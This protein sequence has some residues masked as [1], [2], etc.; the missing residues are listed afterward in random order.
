MIT[1]KSE[2]DP[3]AKEHPSGN[4]SSL[5]D[6]LIEE[7]ERERVSDVLADP[8]IPPTNGSVPPVSD[9]SPTQEAPLAPKLPKK[10][11]NI[12]D[13]LKFLGA[14]FVVGLIFFGSFLAYIVFNPENAQFFVGFG[15]NPADIKSLLAT[16]V[17]AIFGTVAFL[18]SIVWLV[19]LF[20]A[21]RTKKEYRR[22][23][24]VSVIL[25]IFT[26]IVL[27]SSLSLWAYLIQIIDASDYENPDGGVVVYDNDRLLSEQY[28]D[29][30]KMYDF[31]N[32]IGPIT[33][34]FDLAS[35]VR[36]VSRKMQI[37]SYSIDFD[38]D[39]IVD[40]TG[41]DPARDQSIVYTYESVGRFDPVLRY[42]GT[43]TVTREPTE[44]IVSLPSIDIVALVRM[45][46]V[47]ERM[48]GVRARFDAEDLRPIGNVE[49]YVDG[50]SGSAP[51]S[52]DYRFAPSKIF[53]EDG[54]VCLSV[55]QSADEPASC[56]RI[57]VVS[58]G[59]RENA[60]EGEIFE[61]QDVLD[62]L[63]Y[64][65]DL[66][67]DEGKLRVKNGGIEKYEW[68]VDNSA[69]ISADPTAEHKFVGYGK[70]TIAVN[71]T[72]LIGN[73]RKIEKEFIIRER[74]V[75][76]LNADKQSMPV[77]Y[78]AKQAS[79]ENVEISYDPRARSYAIKNVSVPSEFTFD[80]RDMRVTDPLYT[81]EKA[82]WDFDNDGEYETITPE[83]T[84]SVD[85]PKRH[86]LTSRYV[87]T[88]KQKNDT[89]TIIET[90]TIDAERKEVYPDFTIKTS[91]DYVPTIVT[92]DASASSVQRGT[93]SKF[94]I[95][96][97]QGREPQEGDA[98]QNS[99]FELPGTYDIS[100][101]VIRDDG[102]KATLTKK[103]V[104]KEQDNRIVIN[105]SVSS[106]IV[107][108]QVDFDSVGTIGQVETY[109]WKF[110]DGIVSSQPTPT[111]TYEQAGDYTVELRVKFADGSVRTQSL[112]F[113]VKK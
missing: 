75:L 113:S 48:G 81:L 17:S 71:L 3:L 34:R 9:V 73:T 8:A 49:W 37:T 6:A 104:L 96:F 89:Q 50:D 16:L 79:N 90:V 1:P 58:V 51:A 78:K 102:E 56:D 29:S 59:G 22:K 30:A 105:T 36:V 76:D 94:I 12:V 28:A 100:V 4:E 46:V 43:D 33:L 60:I 26:G 11:A 41:T 67:E 109:F 111:H 83:A 54:Y 5:L 93:I 84:F 99:S 107:G 85:T 14:L 95:D 86:I 68:I 2:N 18:L 45:D 87:F 74:L 70:H 24:T 65:F 63:F 42:E 31:A 13:F 91:S 23:K 53:H 27:F 25:A 7:G 10:K 38:A 92:V 77:R 69:V 62:P 44:Q 88:S 19:L 15:I 80:A 32:L 66:G 97:G 110:G 47:P 106:G 64:V 35:N 21:I 55:S 72:D 39:G 112:L 40:K 98:V 108:R 61:E 101:T 57:F 103:L 52:T 20:R 82:E